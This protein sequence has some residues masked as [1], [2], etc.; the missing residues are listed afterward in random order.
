MCLEIMS[1]LRTVRGKRPRPSGWKWKTLPV[2]LIIQ[3]KNHFWLSRLRCG[4]PV[5]WLLG[6]GIGYLSVVGLEA[7]AA[8]PHQ[9]VELDVG[10]L[11]LLVHRELQLAHR[12]R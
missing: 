5:F 9:L 4:R 2:S 6:L 11:G 8:A 1:W 7:H 12:F 10:A 3:S